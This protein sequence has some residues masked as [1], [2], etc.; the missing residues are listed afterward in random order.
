MATDPAAESDGAAVPDPFELAPVENKTLLARGTEGPHLAVRER[1]PEIV[2]LRDQLEDPERIRD[3]DRLQRQLVDAEHRLEGMP[4]LE[5][6]IGELESQL[7]DARRATDDANDQ[8]MKLHDRLT[9]DPQ[10]LADMP[11]SPSGAL[12]SRCARQSIC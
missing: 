8:I 6:R 3:R 9:D 5:L 12:R 10:A 7:S 1:D 11:N 2:R 4:D